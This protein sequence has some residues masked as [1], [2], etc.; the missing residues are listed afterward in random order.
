M[1][2]TVVGCGYLGAV[3]AASLAELGHQVVG[4][5]VDADKVALLAAAKP[6]FYEPGLSELLEKVSATGRLTFT[7]DISAAAGSAAHFIAVGTPQLKDSYAADLSYVDHAIES[8]IPYL[9]P[10]DVVVGKSTVPVGTAARLSARL[11]EADSGAELAWN[12]EFLREGHAIADT[13]RPD[14]LVYGL[15]ADEA[16][17]DRARAVLDE[18]YAVA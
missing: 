6:P 8:L 16:G 7:T 9:A 15:P 14:R 3:H 5:D 10:G 4:I 11:K 2:I 1:K 13:L 18:V 12:P 17:R